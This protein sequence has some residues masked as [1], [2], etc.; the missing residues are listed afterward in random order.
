MILS[1]IVIDDLKEKSGLLFDQAKD[2][3]M[4]AKLILDVTQRSIGVTTLKRLMGYI[5]DDHRTNSYTLNT[6]VLYLCFPT[7]DDYFLARS[8]GSIWGFQD[9]AVYVQQL[10]LNSEVIVK[11]MDRTVRF[12]VIDHEEKKALMVIEAANSSLQPNDILY[13]HKIE[14]GKRLEAE[15]VFRGDLIGNYKTSSELTAVELI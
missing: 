7:W 5:D 9:S 3:D 6:I 4:L 8:V 10:E 1:N 15:K 13:I 11:Y 12:K 2:F 14:K